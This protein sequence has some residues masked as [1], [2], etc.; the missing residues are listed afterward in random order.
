MYLRADTNPDNLAQAFESVAR[1]IR[2]RIER[3]DVMPGGEG[4][5]P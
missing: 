5:V 3:G 4:G 1:E 2:E